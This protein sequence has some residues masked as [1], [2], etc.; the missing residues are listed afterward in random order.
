MDQFNNHP[1]YRKHDLDSV[2]S[3]LWSFYIKNFIA[4]FLASFV[5]NIGMQYLSASFDFSKFY[6]MTDPF[7]M[8]EEMKK[9]I[10]PIAGIIAI[11]FLLTTVLHYYVIYKP[12]DSSVNIFTAVYKSLKYLITYLIIMILF[13]LF[14][15]I[16]MLAGLIV[17]VIGIF[18]SMLYVFM[19]MLFV[20]PILMVEGNNIGNAI[21][22]TFTLSHKHFG[23]NLG[24]TAIFGLIIIVGSIIL[25]SLV[26]LPFSGSF[27]RILTNPEEM[28]KAMDFMTNPWFI[29]LSALVNSLFTPLMPIFATILYFNA[30]AR[31][32]DK[33]TSL[34]TSEPDK[35]R[36]EDLYAKPYSDDHP[37]NPD[38]K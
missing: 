20:M 28:G 35:V 5:V 6:S 4:L 36:V 25:S 37:D 18:F 29:I 22:R 11:T 3:S 34:P 7:A 24:Y 1:L 2:M 19:I 8:L 21:V 38:K 10:L 14:A 13:V 12:I 30:K 32:E 17:F 16:A 27:F 15:S 31:E 23:P 33:F 9:W 26:L